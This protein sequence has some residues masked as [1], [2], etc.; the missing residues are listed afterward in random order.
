[1]KKTIKGAVSPDYVASVREIVGGWLREFRADRGITQADLAAILGITEGTVS[2]MEA[3]KWL[4]LE[5]L[6][7]VSVALDF[8]I[9]LCPKDSNDDLASMMRHRHAIMREAGKEPS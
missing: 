3:G 9:F 4:S 7:K 5:M 1:M 6:I 8:Y 2:K